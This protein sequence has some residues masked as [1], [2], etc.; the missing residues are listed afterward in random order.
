MQLL[1]ITRR[2]QAKCDDTDGTYVTSDYIAGFAQDV[3]EWM[4]IKFSLVDTSFDEVILILP[5]VP[6]GT[7]DLNGYMAAN[8]PLATMVQPWMVRW[9]LPGQDA[10]LFNKADG[11]LDYVRDVGQG[12]PRLDSWAW[13]KN[14]LKLSNFSTA[15]DLEI[16][17]EFLFDPLTSPDNQLQMSQMANRAF[18]CKLASEVGKARG[19]DKWVTTYSA[20]ADEAIEDLQIKMVKFNLKKTRRLSRMS[21]PRPGTSGVGVGVP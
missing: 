15:L 3:Y 17:G 1:D 10:S 4:S 11:P 19:N 6:A 12:I 16:S 18:A 7:P 2:V 14:S 21:R 13:I 8:Q 9:K 20:D 5:A